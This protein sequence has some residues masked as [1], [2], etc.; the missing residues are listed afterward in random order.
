MSFRINYYLCIY[1]IWYVLCAVWFGFYCN[2]SGVG[3]NPNDDDQIQRK[4]W[5]WMKRNNNNP[6][7][8]QTDHNWII[9]N[10]NQI[11]T[12]KECHTAYSFMAY[13]AGA[14]GYD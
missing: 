8:K 9:Y 1:S 4:E 11:W 12:F 6:I 5:N 3:F 7:D 2:V 14:T 13:P 10:V